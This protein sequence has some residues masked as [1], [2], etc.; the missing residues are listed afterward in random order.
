MGDQMWFDDV[1]VIGE[2]PPEAAAARLRQ[3]GEDEV[4]EALEAIREIPSRT[5][6]PDKQ[7]WERPD[8]PWLHTTSRVSC[9]CG[10]ACWQ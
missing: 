10:L 9:L 4:A 7:W 1:P 6:S 3:V 5:F 2:L 8:K